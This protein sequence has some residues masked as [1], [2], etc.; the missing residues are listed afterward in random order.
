MIRYTHIHPGHDFNES[1]LLLQDQ[2]RQ[3]PSEVDL[4]VGGGGCKGQR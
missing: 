1:G 3:F 2:G 4:R